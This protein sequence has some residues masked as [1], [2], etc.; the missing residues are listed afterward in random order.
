MKKYDVPGLSLAM[1]RQGK[2]SVVGTFGWADRENLVAVEPK[3]CFR[4][5]SVSKPITSS[6]M[7]T[8]LQRKQIKLTDPV[9]GKEG[10]LHYLLRGNFPDGKDARRRLHT[11][12]LKHLLEH[13]AGGWGNKK[14]DPMFAKDALGMNHEELIRWTLRN[15]PLTHN[16]GEEYS[17]SNFGFCLLGRVIE[18][19]TKKTYE[20]AVQELILKPSGVHGMAIGGNSIQERLTDEVIYYGQ[21][22]D[23]YSPAMDVRRM[24]AHGGWV[25][26]PIDL[27]RF[28]LRI[29]GF[30]NP[31]DL[32]ESASL[33]TMT[34]PS[35]ANAGYAKGWSV[36]KASNWWYMGSFNG[37]SSIIVRTSDRFAWAVTVNSRS[38][39]KTYGRQLDKLPWS[40]RKSISS[41]PDADLF[42]QFS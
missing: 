38:K 4:V 21:K 15:R 23:A 16:P 5:A 28:I 37:G 11:L 40:I 6:A 10:R 2:L 24:D 35:I 20:S 29:D 12:K 31:S 33:K 42:T 36:N 8:L 18:R 17:Y 32:L 26:T 25:A 41:W 34:R 19:V 14:G 39:D 1:A 27:V 9:F 22:E 7:M 13:A 30:P 3:H